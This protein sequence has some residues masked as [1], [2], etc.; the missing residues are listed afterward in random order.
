MSIGTK[1]D[2]TRNAVVATERQSGKVSRMPNNNMEEA[3][4]MD[5]LQHNVR[6]PAKDMHIMPGIERDSLLSIPKIADANYIAIFNKDQVNIYD[7]NKTTIIVSWGAILRG[8]RCKK[9]NLWQAPLIK[10]ILN[11]NTNT[12]L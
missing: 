11:Y 5:E 2:R 10:K 4:N 3:S 8:W 7:A 1:S 12:V 9:T 6:H